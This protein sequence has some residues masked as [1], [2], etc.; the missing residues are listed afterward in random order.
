MKTYQ[1]KFQKSIQSINIQT[2]NFQSDPKTE[3]VNQIFFL[4]DWM[5]SHRFHP[6]PQKLLLPFDHQIQNL[7]QNIEEEFQNDRNQEDEIEEKKDEIKEKEKQITR[8]QNK[9]KKEKREKKK[10]ERIK[11]KKEEEKRKKERDKKEK[12]S[13]G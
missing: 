7:N 1:K 2:V 9:I 10:Q 3:I 12:K 6:P 11:R 4:L 13:R 5:K 8:Y